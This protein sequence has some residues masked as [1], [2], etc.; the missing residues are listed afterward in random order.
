MR[1]QRDVPNTLYYGMDVCD[2]EEK[3]RV[4]RRV[5]SSVPFNELSS[6]S[7][8]PADGNASHFPFVSASPP[9]QVTGLTLHS[10]TVSRLRFASRPQ[11][12]SCR[13]LPAREG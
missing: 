8:H 2:K 12:G 5:V 13:C 7:S 1:M 6:L 3:K 9:A 4:G 10:E 11:L